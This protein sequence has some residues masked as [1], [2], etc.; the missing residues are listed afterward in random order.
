MSH[1]QGKISSGCDIL[2]CYEGAN[3]VW[4]RHQRSVEGGGERR[5]K[6]SKQK[7]NT[8]TINDYFARQ[9]S[10]W[11]REWEKDKEDKGGIVGVRGTDGRLESR[12][13]N[14][15]ENRRKKQTVKG[16]SGICPP[17][18]F[19]HRA[20]WLGCWSQ[21]VKRQPFWEGRL[22]WRRELT[23]EEDRLK[24]LNVTCEAVV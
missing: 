5:R 14:N 8:H 16:F 21:A 2:A 18:Y 17:L 6:E 4:I 20:V 1:P 11:E 13:C 19:S 9:H 12:R 7:R 24:A 22:A 3:C 15:A 23:G 10:S